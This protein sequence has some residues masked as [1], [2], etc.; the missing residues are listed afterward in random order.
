MSKYYHNTVYGMHMTS[1]QSNEED[2]EDNSSSVYDMR[3]L[4]LSTE[5]ESIQ[6]CEEYNPSDDMKMLLH[7]ND[8]PAKRRR[9]RMKMNHGNG[10]AE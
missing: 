9:N 3:S 1:S 2:Q 7:E 6:T 8:D 4:S 5:T 10:I